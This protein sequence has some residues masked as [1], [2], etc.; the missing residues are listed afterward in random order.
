M[1][2]SGLIKIRHHW[3]GWKH[4]EE[5]ANIDPYILYWGY[6]KASHGFTPG[7]SLSRRSDPLWECFPVLVYS[8][9][10][11]LFTGTLLMTTFASDKV[12]GFDDAS[13]EERRRCHTRHEGGIHHSR[14][15]FPHPPYNPTEIS[16]SASG[17]IKRC[18]HVDWMSNIRQRIKISLYRQSYFRRNDESRLTIHWIRKRFIST[19]LIEIQ[20]S[21]SLITMRRTFWYFYWQGLCIWRRKQCFD[22]KR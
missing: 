15:F 13:N 21:E 7:T 9:L 10:I 18:D 2:P 22:S 4:W 11:I 6:G 8:C 17:V 12:F 20:D 19:D 5:S 14:S 1:L 16:L 3:S